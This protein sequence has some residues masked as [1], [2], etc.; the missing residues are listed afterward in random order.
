MKR[1]GDFTEEERERMLR[2]MKDIREWEK[3]SRE[4]DKKGCELALIITLLP[5][6]T[7]AVMVLKEML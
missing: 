4:K 7:L 6:V 1:V 5:F 3:R 2:T